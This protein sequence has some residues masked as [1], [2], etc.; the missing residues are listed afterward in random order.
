MRTEP[1]LACTH[2]GQPCAAR[3]VG[4][5]D[6][7]VFCCSG[8]ATVYEV[9]HGAGLARYYTTREALPAAP[10]DATD[11]SAA[12]ALDDPSF[13]ARYLHDPEGR[14]GQGDRVTLSVRG[15]HCGS[16]GWVI[17]RLLDGDPAVA[18]VRVS[19]GD[20]RAVVELTPEGAS[21]PPLGR[22]VRRLAAAGYGGAPLA[23]PLGDPDESSRRREVRAEM[24]R[25]GVAAACAMNLGLFAVSL[26]GGERWGMDPELRTMFQWL[27]LAVATPIVAFSA[28]PIL[29]RAFAALRAGVIHVDVPLALAILVMYGAS[30]VAT[31]R[32]V[33]AVWFDSLGMLVLLLLGGR[34]LEGRVRRQTAQRLRTLAQGQQGSA[35]RLVDGAA[36]RVPADALRAGDRVRLQP[37]DVCPVDAEVLS[38]Q[39]DVDLSVVDGESRPVLLV[40]GSEI[41]AGARVL[42]GTLDAAVLRPAA[43]SGVARTRAL[44][45]R[46]LWR[47]GHV[48]LIAD[49]VARWFVGVVLILAVGTGAAWWSIDPARALPV[50]VSVLVVACPCAL[51]LAT[52]LAFAA[53]L[54]G[55]AGAGLLMRDPSSLLRLGRVRLVAFDKTGT[56]TESVPTAGPVQL[57]GAGQE[58]GEA[59]VL[60]L[61]AALCARSHHPVSRAVVTACAERHPGPLPVPSDVREEAGVGV[62]GRVSGRTVSVGRPGA[63]IVVDGVHVADLAIGQAVREGAGDV[64][65]E[66]HRMGLCTSLLSGDEEARAR[67]EGS[68]LGIQSA[69]GGLSPTDKAHI[70]SE[71]Q[72]SGPVLFVGDG[73]NDAAALAGADVG[74]AMGG[75]VELAL[76]A[77]DGVLLSRR[78]GVVADGIRL[79][80]RLDRTVRSNIAVSVLYNALA[81]TGAALGLITPL[82]AATLMPISSLVVVVRA[83]RLARPPR[84]A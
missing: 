54:R 22:L 52:P 81:V 36:E 83:G 15:M 48:E 64:V 4:G 67:A 56:L 31:V 68:R 70:V 40:I 84:D 41:P 75:S 26:Y 7:P 66:L 16:C 35:T 19:L 8:C 43:A 34:A 45:D 46:A 77:A 73:L 76:Q 44:V 61:A 30:A 59:K 13:A 71:A 69:R 23:E 62:T 10:P 60:R 21:A 47:R 82:V 3:A 63:K 80:R 14:I 58:L 29:Q 6:A 57:T 74:L 28:G 39:S 78:P 55:A 32:G 11:D 2:C 17:E 79:G 38:G 37:G 49:R 18:C 42:D 25:L 9:L 50:V 5:G 24:L 53:A 1:G 20:E 72:R 27:S 65:D 12:S 51:A 33:G